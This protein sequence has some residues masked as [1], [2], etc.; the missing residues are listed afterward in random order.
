MS[1]NT[2]ERKLASR[3]QRLGTET[4]YNVAAEARELSQTGKTI[5]PFHIGIARNNINISSFLLLEILLYLLIQR[6]SV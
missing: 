1:S 5:Y 4:A 3:L 2:G 6:Q